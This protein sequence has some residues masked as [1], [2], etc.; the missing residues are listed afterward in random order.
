MALFKKRSTKELVQGGASKPP[1]PVKEKPARAPSVNGGAPAT[2]S[3]GKTLK[4]RGFIALICI[5]LALVLAVF[6]LPRLY[7]TQSATT[8]IVQL[9]INVPAGT[10]ISRE[11][12]T[13]VKVGAFGLP[14]GIA[15]EI[16]PVIG[17]IAAE[18]LFSGEYLWLG[19]L[20][21]AEDYQAET[22]E[23]T[24]GLGA[25]KCLVTISF[26][27]ASAGVGGVL[28]TGDTVDVF[29]FKKD[30]EGAYDVTKVLTG[31]SVYDVLNDDFESLSDLDEI[32]ESGKDGGANY[33]F[34]PEYV[35]FLCTE[36][37]AKTLIRLEK[38]GS[39]HLV[40]KE[41]GGR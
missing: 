33:D 16:D 30:P 17:M 5:A 10:A 4:S 27:S 1:K 34:R 25:G 2:T 39:L 12:V 23:Q 14:D 19:R 9:R 29:E 22:L 3:A 7:E 28:R 6:V 18:D 40:L 15:R 24:K 11:M 8:N 37:Q 13:S 38:A 36:A 41:S 21:A 31:I 35:V 20:K 26:S 32:I